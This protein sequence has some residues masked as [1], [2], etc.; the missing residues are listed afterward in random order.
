MANI[1]AAS[2]AIPYGYA[3]NFY[4]GEGF[5]GHFVTKEGSFYEDGTLKHTC[6]SLYDDIANKTSSIEVYKTATLGT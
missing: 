5:N 1:Q 4:D 3:V 2:A 6:V